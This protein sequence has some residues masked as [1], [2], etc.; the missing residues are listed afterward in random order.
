MEFIW[1]FI[2]KTPIK[3]PS[4][5]F[6]HFTSFKLVKTPKKCLIFWDLIGVPINKV[7]I[8]NSEF[9]LHSLYFLEMFQN[10]PK[11]H[12]YQ[13]LQNG[14]IRGLQIGAGFRDYKSGKEGLQIGVVQGISNRAGDFISGQRDFKSG[15]RLPIGA[16]KITNRGRAFKLEQGLQIGVEQPQGLFT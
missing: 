9:M 7:L 12:I 15:Q 10:H 6:I 5:F 1:Q 13:G 14:T 11:M 2:Q 4:M 16:R 3:I 8:K